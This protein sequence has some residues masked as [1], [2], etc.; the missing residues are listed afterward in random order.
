MAAAWLPKATVQ[1]PPPPALSRPHPALH[2]LSTVPSEGSVHT[3]S[4]RVNAECTRCM[5]VSADCTRC[6][7]VC[8]GRAGG[9]RRGGARN[10]QKPPS[11]YA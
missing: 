1:V 7:G 5:G 11:C 4:A 9:A 6:M 2:P 3:V 8:A 10:G